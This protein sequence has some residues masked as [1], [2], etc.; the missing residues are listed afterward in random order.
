[1]SMTWKGKHPVV[2]MVE[3]IDATGVKL[4]PQ[5]RS[6]DR[7]FGAPEDRFNTADFRVVRELKPGER[8]PTQSSG[9]GS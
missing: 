7:E 4:T 1:M 3:A 9:P 8:L 2:S 5:D 6:A